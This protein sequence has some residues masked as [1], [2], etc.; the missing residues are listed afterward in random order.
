MKAVRLYP[1][2]HNYKLSDPQCL[3]LVRTAAAQ[4]MAISIPVRVE[5]RRQ[6]SWL[7]DVPDVNHE[8]IAT[9]VKSVPDARFLLHNGNGFIR[10]SLGT[11]DSG[12]PSNYVID[13]SLLTV[14]LANEAGRL[15]ANLGDDRV[16]F[17]TGMPFH[18][19]D[20]ALA[21]LELLDV[22]ES[23]KQKIRGST[24]ASLLG[25]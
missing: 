4:R 3:D 19:P 21:K 14:E 2:W 18:Y 25:I 11:R 1:R 9:L 15:L 10:S 13:I 5:D 12:L 23:V 17:G 7:V 22:S 24:A 6:Q 16:V 8:E 20:P